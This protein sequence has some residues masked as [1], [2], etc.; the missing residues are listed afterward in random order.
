MGWQDVAPSGE[1]HQAEWIRG[2]LLAFREAKI[3]SVIPTGFAAYVKIDGRSDLTDILARHTTTPERCWFCLWDGYGYLTGAVWEFRAYEVGPP[4]QPP[5][6]GPFARK[7]PQPKLQRSRVRLPNRDYLLFSGAVEQGAGWQD[8]PNL[9]WPA[10][11]AWC[12]ASEIDLDYTLVGGSSEL[13]A[14]LVAFRAS[15]VSPDDRN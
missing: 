2:R 3:G 7:P 6:T 4:G 15:A 5:P 9:W 11:R 10:D 14:E 13:C 8:G 12:V 1:V